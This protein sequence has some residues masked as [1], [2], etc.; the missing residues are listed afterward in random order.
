MNSDE[1]FDEMYGH[2][3]VEISH[4]KDEE[5]K[6]DEERNPLA[7]TLQDIHSQLAEQIDIKSDLEGNIPDYTKVGM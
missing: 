1:Y 5:E 6:D 7:Y 4:F 3:I 2:V